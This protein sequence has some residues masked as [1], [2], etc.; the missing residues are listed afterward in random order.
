MRKAAAASLW[1]GT[2]SAT[3]V[4]CSGSVLDSPLPT[5]FELQSPVLPSPLLTN[6]SGQW[7]PLRPAE[8][9]DV[10]FRPGGE[11]SGD[12]PKGQRPKDH[13]IPNGLWRRRRTGLLSTCAACAVT[14]TQAHTGRVPY[15]LRSDSSLYLQYIFVYT[16]SNVLALDQRKQGQ[17]GAPDSFVLRTWVR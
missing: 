17:R 3:V 7:A 14:Y 2:C 15:I 16:S 10:L 1:M 12:G 4:T 9:T 11:S 8:A 6:S 13:D 5:I